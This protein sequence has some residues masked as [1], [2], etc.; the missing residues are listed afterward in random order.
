MPESSDLT[1]SK[2]ER[3]SNSDQASEVWP[4]IL[5]LTMSESSSSV[6]TGTP[7]LT[8]RNPGRRYSHQNRR[9]RRRT[10]RRRDVGSGLRRSRQP[11]RWSGPRQDHQKTKSLDQGSG[12][13]PQKV[14]QRAYAN[15]SEGRRRTRPHRPRTAITH[16]R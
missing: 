14:S 3:W 7:N 13:H 2:Q 1:R 4:S 9:H 16:H 6:T 11:H 5:K 12:H 8:Q 15:R 10:H